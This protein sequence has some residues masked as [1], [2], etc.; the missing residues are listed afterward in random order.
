MELS[1]QE[2]QPRSAYAVVSTGKGN[3]EFYGEEG[4][5]VHRLG[6]HTNL[7]IYLTQQQ[8]ENCMN[9]WHGADEKNDYM[10]VR[11]I[12]ITVHEEV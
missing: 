5:I 9:G 12:T 3:K 6:E 8:A 1:K 2:N 11:R 4:A 7:D 10:R